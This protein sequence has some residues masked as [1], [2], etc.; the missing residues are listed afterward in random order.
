[1]IAIMN[2]LKFVH[3]PQLIEM[4]ADVG[5]LKW[6]FFADLLANEEGTER[7]EYFKDIPE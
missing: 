5:R 1:M 4:E 3:S 6:R 7:D 2:E